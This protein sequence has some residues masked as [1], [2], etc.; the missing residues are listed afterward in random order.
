LRQYGEKLVCVRYRDDLS[1]GQRYKTVELIIDEWS[2]TA[3]RRDASWVSVRIA[4]H[5][6]GLRALIKSA[7]G[8]WDRE[9]RVWWLRIEEVKRLGLGGRVTDRAE[10]CPGGVGS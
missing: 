6:Q 3:E 2:D 4:Y 5:E 8:Y 1:G 9:K 10:Q 7:G